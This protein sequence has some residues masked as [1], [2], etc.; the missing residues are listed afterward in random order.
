MSKRRKCYTIRDA[1]IDGVYKNYRKNVNM[2]FFELLT[3]ARNPF[4]RKAGLSR[5]PIRH[6]LEL[7]RTPKHKWNMKHVRWA[8]KSIVFIKRLK[9]T[10]AG[11][12]V[13][14]DCPFSRKTISLKNLGYNPNKR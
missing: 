8:N 2:S 12:P 13:S 3:W 7:L 14:K 11:S 6:S 9:L 5:R 4:S 1:L 10:Y